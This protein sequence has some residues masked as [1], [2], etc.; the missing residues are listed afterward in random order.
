M[1]VAVD[2]ESESRVLEH[3]ICA[4][5]IAGVFKGAQLHSYTL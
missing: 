5:Q 4:M 2:R 1:L 3:I